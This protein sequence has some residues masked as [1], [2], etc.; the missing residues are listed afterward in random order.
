[1]LGSDRVSR[2]LVSSGLMTGFPPQFRRLAP[3]LSPSVASLRSRVTRTPISP[4][5]AR[6]VGIPARVDSFHVSRA[7]R[8][9]TGERFGGSRSP[10]RRRCAKTGTAGVERARHSTRRSTP[11]TPLT[12]DCRAPVSRTRPHLR[13]TPA[14]PSRA[15]YSGAPTAPRDGPLNFSVVSSIAPRRRWR[16]RGSPRRRRTPC[17]PFG[18][19]AFS[20]RS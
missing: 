7:G 19:G 11:L 5:T 3:A 6:A 20:P 9:R 8:R 15:R 4:D 10:A 16:L 1:M 18:G 2:R 13:P 14:I 17:P 12:P